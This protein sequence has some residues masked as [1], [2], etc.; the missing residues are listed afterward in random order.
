M[1]KRW[2]ER[3]RV[4]YVEKGIPKEHGIEHQTNHLNLYRIYHLIHAT[5]PVLSLTQSCEMNTFV[6]HTHSQMKSLK[7]MGCYF[8]QLQ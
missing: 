1:E 8:P 7:E 6:S 5:P 4:S 2:T 3:R